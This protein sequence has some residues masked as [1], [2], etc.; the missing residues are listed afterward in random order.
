MSSKEADRFFIWE[1]WGL[2]EDG[3]ELNELNH[4]FY[5]KLH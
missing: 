5:F 3:C 4:H 1:E 2:L